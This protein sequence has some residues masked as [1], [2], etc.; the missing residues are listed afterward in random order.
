MIMS[1]YIMISLSYFQRVLH[2]MQFVKSKT[3]F[4]NSHNSSHST[5][6]KK[7]NC[8]NCLTKWTEQGLYLLISPPGPWGRPDCRHCCSWCR[9]QSP[10]R[11]RAGGSGRGR[12]PRSVTAAY[13]GQAGT[14]CPQ[15]LQHNHSSYHSKNMHRY[16]H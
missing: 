2:C 11:W 13:W 1:Q 16:R 10:R 5:C 3:L 6:I 15:L 9:G 4:Y 12:A 8:Y 14:Y 7:I